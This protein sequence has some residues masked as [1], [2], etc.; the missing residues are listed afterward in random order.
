MMVYLPFQK[1][2]TSTLMP[3]YHPLKGW[4]SKK[5][6]A[7]GKRSIVFRPQ[8][9]YSD[10]PVEVPCGQCIGCRLERSRQWA[11][12]CV[13][14]SQLYDDNCFITLTYSDES[15]PFDGSLDVSH[16]QLFMKRLRKRFG[17]GI[18]F[19]HCGEYGDQ[20]GRPHYHACIFNFDFPDKVPFKQLDSGGMLYTSAALSELWPFGLHSIGTVTFESAAYVARYVTKK[21]TGKNAAAHYERFDPFTGEVFFLKPEYITM[22]RR[23]GVGKGWFDRFSGDVYPSDE[24]V[25]NG[26]SMRPPKF[27]DSQFEL[28]SPE[29][30][31]KLKLLREANAA[32]FADNN[33]GDRLAVRE[34]CQLSRFSNLKRPLE[35]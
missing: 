28:L 13:H 33:T 20:L 11:I 23:P 4:R 35:G 25:L 7:N 1:P 9:G 31:R 2:L 3:C 18:R 27:Y 26:V 21:V 6:T 19:F 15:L 24:V 16:F 22:S 17:S 5:L 10:M 34:V 32:K 14:E 29:S 12:R 30:L 8:E